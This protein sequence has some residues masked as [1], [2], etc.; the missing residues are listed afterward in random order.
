MVRIAGEP[1]LG[2]ILDSLSATAIDDVVLVVGGPMQSQIREYA[3]EQFGDRFS[4]V[5]T[6]QVD[7]EGLGHA[8]YQ[9][10]EAVGGE[11]LL[12]ALG[13]ML[14]EHGYKT[15]IEAHEA[16]GDISGSIGVKEVSEPQHYGVADIGADGVIQ[17]LIEK[18]D[19]PPSNKAIS[20]AYIINDS[21]ALFDALEHLIENNLRGAGDEYQL[22][23]A[24]Q[25]MVDTGATLKTFNVTDWYDCGRPETL[26]E[27]NR[28]QLQRMET[29]AES[30]IDDSVI[31]PPVDIGNDVVVERSVIGPNVSLDDGTEITD[32]IIRDSIVGRSASLSSVNIESSIIG[33][34]ASISGESQSLNVGDNS[35]LSL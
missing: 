4:F 7:A 31:I 6:E 30:G 17:E 24:L 16:H 23:D 14:F 35:H 18:P 15:F 20:G 2:H 1:I 9:T 26:L 27:A 8:I 13:D 34:G 32:S 19:Q 29:S 10:R 25:R 12:I 22:T 21:T 28:V 33:D 5:F 11:E 3:T